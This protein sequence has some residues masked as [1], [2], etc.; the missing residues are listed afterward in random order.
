MTAETPAFVRPATHDLRC[1]FGRV[2]LGVRIAQDAQAHAR[3]VGLRDELQ[4]AAEAART[5]AHVVEAAAGAAG[6]GPCRGQRADAVV[7][8][9][10]AQGAGSRLVDRANAQLRGP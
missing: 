6:D 4:L 1:G 8:H 9:L 2:A 3:A 10:D 7:R 5:L